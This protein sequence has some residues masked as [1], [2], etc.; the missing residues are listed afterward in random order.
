MPKLDDLIE[1]LVIANRIL[2]REDVVDAFGHVS[3]RHPQKPERY[4]LSRARA[5]TAS[6]PATS[7]SSRSTAT[8]VERA[9]A[10]PISSASST[11][12]ST[13]RGRKS[14]RSCT[15]TARA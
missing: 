8:P 10:R 5:R 15:I 13:K 12:R 7:W 2:A 6:R 11:A 1:D 3:V 9:T 4:L 14:T